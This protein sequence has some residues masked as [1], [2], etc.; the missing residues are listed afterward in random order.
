VEDIWDSC[1]RSRELQYLVKWKRFPE[2]ENTWEP[3]A[4]LG[5]SMELVEEFH[6]A[7]LE[8]SN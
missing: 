2:E 7:N 6:Q 1:I 3:A 5:N 8:K 4:H